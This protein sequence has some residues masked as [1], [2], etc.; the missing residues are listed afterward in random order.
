M[1][2]EEDAITNETLSTVDL[3]DLSAHTGSDQAAVTPDH[4]LKIMHLETQ[5]V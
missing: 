4:D 5:H 3:D 2:L 1:S